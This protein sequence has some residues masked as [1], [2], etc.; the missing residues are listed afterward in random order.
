MPEIFLLPSE[1]HSSGNFSRQ[2]HHSSC[3]PAGAPWAKAL[4][5]ASAVSVTMA[6][7]MFVPAAQELATTA[8]LPKS[9][10]EALQNVQNKITC[11]ERDAGMSN[12]GK[13][14]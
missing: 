7:A 14:A 1:L 12:L 6:N 8:M 10:E 13:G 4:Q 11:N 9:G 2:P 3:V 5:D